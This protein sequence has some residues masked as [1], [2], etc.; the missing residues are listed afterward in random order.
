[1]GS[2]KDYLKLMEVDKDRELLDFKKLKHEMDMNKRLNNQRVL[3]IEEAI[4]NTDKLIED[5]YMPD[6]LIGLEK[7]LDYYPSSTRLDRR[8][9]MSQ[10]LNFEPGA[11]KYNS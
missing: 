9:P 7:K 1:M 10:S 6:E 4:I 8:N 11:L 2:F 5:D 3:K